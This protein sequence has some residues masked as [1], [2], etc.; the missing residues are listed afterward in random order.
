MKNK[1]LYTFIIIVLISFQGNSQPTCYHFETPHFTVHYYK[2]VEQ[3]A[4]KA[5]TIAE[6]IYGP[7][8]SLYD[9]E[10]SEKVRLVFKDNE[11]FANGGAYYFD[12]KIE[13]WAENLDFVLRGTHFWLR[14]VITHEF[15]HIVNLQKAMKLGMHIPGI[16]LQYF[17]Y[18]KEKRPDV[19]R[20]FP[21]I[22]ASFPIVTTSFPA[23]FAEGTAQYQCN[24]KRYDY[25]DSHREMILRDRVLTDKLLSVNE[26]STF[27]KTSVGNESSYNQ[28]FA[29][30]KYLAD[31]YGEDKLSQLAGRSSH[32]T[33][34]TFEQTMKHVF[35]RP[36]K[37]IYNE[38]HTYLK[39]KYKKQINRI[40]IPLQ[41]GV[42]VED[43]GF[44]N[45]YPL[46][47]PN[48]EKLAYVS[49][50]DSPGFGDNSLIIAEFKNGIYEKKIIDHDITSSL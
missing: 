30:V 22:L 7:I 29:F 16:Y 5:A 2:G 33:E 4:Y 37:D 50:G 15:T 25:R 48:G 17:R 40:K 42:P 41:E 28:G 27:G 36:L 39:K 35:K 13:I 18:E 9:F 49:N 32:L 31:T 21:N 20:G 3:T 14:D 47:S 10:P 45:L 23:W 19:V 1:L 6:E 24:A 11:D 46:F 26:M 8:T 12:N 38:W 34:L 44:G 43:K